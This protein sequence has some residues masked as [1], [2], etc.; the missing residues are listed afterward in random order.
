MQRVVALSADIWHASLEPTQSGHLSVN[1]R[2]VTTRLLLAL[3]PLLLLLLILII[4]TLYV[5]LL[6]SLLLCG[7]IAAGQSIPVSGAGSFPCEITLPVVWEGGM[8]VGKGNGY[9]RPCTANAIQVT[10]ATAATTNTTTTE[11][12]YGLFYVPLIKIMWRKVN[13]TNG[14]GWIWRA[15]ERE[16]LLNS[17]KHFVVEQLVVKSHV[18]ITHNNTD[19]IYSQ[20][21]NSV[22]PYNEQLSFLQHATKPALQAL[23]ML[24]AVILSVCPSVCLSVTLWCCVKTRKRRGMR[25]SPSGSPVSLVFWRQEFPKMGFRYPNFTFCA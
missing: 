11:W 15:V 9:N 3:P 17:F 23:Y 1:H 10:T 2:T 21:L 20:V 5:S 12:H 14:C 16:W 4:V 7:T 22:T 25:S 19:V 18:L 6:A 13:H 24:R 8:Q